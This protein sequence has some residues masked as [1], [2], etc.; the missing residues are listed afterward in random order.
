[1]KKIMLGL[2]ASA[3]MFTMASSAQAAAHSTCGDVT[4]A[5]FNWA[6]GELMANVDKFILEAGYGCNVEL[7]QGGTTQIFASMNEKGSPEIA[8]ELW[9]NAVRDL[10]DV[11]VK[12]GRMHVAVNGPITELGE[13][14]WI[15]PAFAEKHPELDTVEK[16]IERP[17]L[18][19]DAEDS[20]KGAFIGC[21]AGWGCQLSNA[22]LFRAFDMEAKGWRLVDPGSAAGLDGSMAKAAERGEP[23]LGYYWSPTAAIGKYNMKL[24]KWETPYAG[25]E[26]WDGCIALPEQE[27]ADP[28]PTS[29]TESVVDT[30]VTD[31]FKQK[32]S[33]ALTYLEKRIFPGSVMNAML[34]YMGEEQASGADATIEF[35]EKHEDVWMSWVTPEVAAKVKAAM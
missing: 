1:M 25:T 12:E 18:F 6:S 13:G 17:D 31:S 20:S 5:E 16:I 3:A 22:N 19:P 9:S 7:V 35:L 34:V 24:L 28:K 33:E 30:V 11:A 21:P 23:W 8:G 14:W 10:L 2:A 32:S 29:Y 26:N 27:C 4:M 15:T